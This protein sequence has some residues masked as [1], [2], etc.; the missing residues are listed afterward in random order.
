MFVKISMHL[1]SLAQRPR[2]TSV[3]A[4][5]RGSGS[6]DGRRSRIRETTRTRKTCGSNVKA[7]IRKRSR[8]TISTRRT[9]WTAAAVSTTRCRGSGRPGLRIYR[10]VSHVGIPPTRTVDLSFLRPLITRGAI[11]RHVR[12][13]SSVCKNLFYEDQFRGFFDDPFDPRSA[14]SYTL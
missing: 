1:L 8:S 4:K 6:G 3:I 12:V 9:R 11:S 5:R 14:R 2:R 10:Y 13:I 7:C